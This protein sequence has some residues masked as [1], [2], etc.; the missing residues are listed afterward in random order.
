MNPSIQS[1]YAM[2]ARIYDATRWT[3]LFG[4]ERILRRLAKI[5]EPERILEV[6]CGTGRNLRRLRRIFPD[7]EITGV[8]LSGD[9]LKV[10]RRK[11]DGVK[12]IQQAYDAPLLGNF[13]L[14]LFSYALSMFN[15]G[16]EHAIRAAKA[17]L[18]PGGLLAIV[19]F[20]HSDSGIFRR[21]MGM[22]HVRMEG[23]LWPES[24]MWF[25]PMIDERHAAYG[26][27]WHYGMFIGL[28]K[29]GLDAIPPAGLI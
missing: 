13:D 17:D 26:G 29:N 4:R 16:W 11:T 25:E 24:R 8:D 22:N 14:I 21:W 7:A 9:M 12:L 19:D 6:G 28:E 10:A 3:F 23:H 27:I 20:S 18:A 1:Y 2:H 5:S 15:P